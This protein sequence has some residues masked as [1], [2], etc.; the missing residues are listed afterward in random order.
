MCLVRALPKKLARLPKWPLPALQSSQR[1]THLR[2]TAFDWLRSRPKP[3]TRV[4]PE[5]PKKD[6][7]EARLQQPHA[8]IVTRLTPPL[9]VTRALEVAVGHDALLAA[10]LPKLAK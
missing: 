2:S 7:L 4:E 8:V 3:F 10:T 5:T 6:A 9:L 1:H